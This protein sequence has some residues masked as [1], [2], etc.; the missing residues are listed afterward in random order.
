MKHYLYTLLF[1]LI[2]V[3]SYAQ[4][5]PMLSI[6]GFGGNDYDQPF[7]RVVKT[8]DGG[9]I[10]GIN[11]FSTTGSINT[12]CVINTNGEYIF[13][14]YSADGNTKEWEKCYT[15]YVDSIVEY[16]FPLPHNNFILGEYAGSGVGDMLRI[17]RKD[18]L[19]NLIWSKYYG[20]S[21]QD[22][23]RDMFATNDGGYIMLS[24]SYSDDGDV[25]KHYGSSF[26]MDMWILKLDSNGNKVWSTVIGGTNDEKPF[27]LAQA[28]HGGCY[29]MGAT[30]SSDYDCTGFKGA[31]DAYIARLDTNGNLLW[32][33]C[34]GGTAD[35]GVYGW[36]IEDGK[37]GVLVVSGTYSNDGDVHNSH[38]GEDIWLVDVDSSNNILWDNCYGGVS[39]EYPNTMCRGMDGTIWIAGKSYLASGEVATAYGKDDAWIVH[40]DSVGN[41]LNA[42]VIGTSS[43]DQA[44]MISPLN[45]GNVMVGGY[46]SDSVGGNIPTTTWYGRYD[47]FLAILEPWN[48]GINEVQTINS[49][50]TIY[51]NPA[52]DKVYIN[53]VFE[54]QSYRILNVIG[55]VIQQGELKQGDNTIS[56]QGLASGVYVLELKDNDGVKEWRR[57]VKE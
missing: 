12:S 24:A 33:H 11:S 44:T 31:Q 16:I 54:N 36:C 18:S 3:H 21:R 32:H 25:G 57:V 39:E 5:I 48:V 45:N 51:P 20:G 41:F 19:G 27:S 6:Q 35:D 23:L 29:V 15:Y 34:L 2:T 52:H 28:P 14:K 4:L 47:V 26:T 40:T 49:Y 22:F 55:S 43:W 8:M 7:E 53:K 17:C 9:F 56:T 42:K 50:G 46:Y 13:Q 1:L 10:I 37:G 30:E 38:G